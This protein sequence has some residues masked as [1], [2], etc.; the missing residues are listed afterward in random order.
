ML[1]DAWQCLAR[2]LKDRSGHVN[3]GYV[4]KSISHEVGHTF[5]KEVELRHTNRCTA[6]HSLF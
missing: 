5:G 4:W 1:A 2:N 6:N 3:L